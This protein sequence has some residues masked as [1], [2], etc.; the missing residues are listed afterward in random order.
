MRANKCV[1]KRIIMPISVQFAVKNCQTQKTTE[2]EFLLP[3]QSIKVVM[4]RW[5]CKI[6]VS[7]M[8]PPLDSTLF[9]GVTNYEFSRTYSSITIF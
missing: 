7:L 1:K 9:S 6:V 5:H 3:D 8:Y 4:V 2:L